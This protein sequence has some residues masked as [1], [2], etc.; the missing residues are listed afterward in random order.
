MPA[1]GYQVTLAPGIT[2]SSYLSQ[3]QLYYD[4]V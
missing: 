1:V 3:H 4:R 2:P